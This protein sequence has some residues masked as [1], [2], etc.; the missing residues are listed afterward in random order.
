MSADDTLALADTFRQQQLPQHQAEQQPLE[1]QQPQVID[2]AG[3]GGG[4]GGSGESSAGGGGLGQVDGD[5]EQLIAAEQVL[6]A[7]LRASAPIE[8]ELAQPELVSRHHAPT[9][10]VAAPVTVAGAGAGGRR[11][12]PAQV[13]YAHHAPGEHR[14]QQR[15][16][17][18][19][20]TASR[21]E[22]PT[23]SRL[24]LQ[25]PARQFMNSAHAAA[26]AAAAAAAERNGQLNGQQHHMSG[27]GMSNNFD[28]NYKH[29]RPFD[30]AQI[31]K[32]S[33]KVFC[34]PSDA[35]RPIDR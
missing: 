30:V 8:L 23:A 12:V 28:Y 19:A 29:E 16:R 22:A 13:H 25:Q 21:Q 6:P 9:V 14:A 15:R 7:H 33:E 34:S 31:R 35:D 26:S 2:W 32:Y 18:E 24:V 1:I 27:S 4:G 3:G 17:Q 5:D 10:P 20:P 11:Q